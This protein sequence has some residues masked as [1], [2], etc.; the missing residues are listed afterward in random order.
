MAL[1]ER[2]YLDPSLRGEETAE[3]IIK[4]FS[5]LEA[6]VKG[7]EEIKREV[8]LQADDP[9][10]KGKKILLLS[11]YPGPLVKRCPGT[12]GYI[13]CGYKVI[14]L[15]VNCPMDCSYCIL[16]SYLN[17]PYIVLYPHFEKIFSEVKVMIEGAP[18]GRI[19]RFGT[20]ELS[21]SLALDEEIGFSQEA[22]PFFSS[23]EAILELKTKT[24]RVGHLLKLPHGGKTVISWSLNPPKVVREEEHLTARLEERLMAAK[25]VQ[26]AGYPVGVHFDPIIP[27]P[28]WQ[29]DYLRL[30]DALFSHL[31]PRGV[32]WIS[33]GTFRLPPALKGIVRE[34][35]PKSGILLGELLPAEDG[36]FRYLKPLR[37][38]IYRKMYQWL[39]GY[40][41][42]L[43][44][45]LCMEREDV[46]QEV[47]GRK[48]GGTAALTDLFDS[49]VREFFRRW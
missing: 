14:N 15:L 22:I 44:I 49:R 16:Q 41:D 27:Y 28:G 34:R 12:K 6:K 37:I 1:I 3:R 39:R 25:R 10:T 21:D 38:D 26:E 43:F 5:P 35:F 30:I 18:E 9:L 29:E 20:G 46:W 45:Y 36:K 33:L 13:C 32:I 4:A 7:G 11:P 24:A 23:L 48:P 47:F 8:M 17:N 19:L 40:G 31:D 42:D 2:L